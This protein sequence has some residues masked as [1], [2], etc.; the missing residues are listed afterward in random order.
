[1]NYGLVTVQ[2]DLY[3]PLLLPVKRSKIPPICSFPLECLVGEEK[4]KIH[5][6]QDNEVTSD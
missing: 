2:G 4:Q 3:R 6:Y 5:T 1:M